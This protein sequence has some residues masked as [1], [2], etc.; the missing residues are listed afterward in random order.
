MGTRLSVPT[1]QTS[2]P[3]LRQLPAVGSLWL[4]SS[5][6]LRASGEGTSLHYFRGY[7]RMRWDEERRSERCP[8]PPRHLAIVS[9]VQRSV[10]GFWCL[11]SLLQSSLI[12]VSALCI[13][14]SY[15][16]FSPFLQ[17]SFFSLLPLVVS[18]ASFVFVGRS[19][20]IYRVYL[21]A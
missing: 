15:H 14:F 18:V 8:E 11:R 7:A 5:D 4:R 16:C 19:L 21:I 20:G 10:V 1:F 13:M 9:N 6:H 2:R 17:Y 12:L 3:F